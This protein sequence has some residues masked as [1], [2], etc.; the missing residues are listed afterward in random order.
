M[1]QITLSSIQFPSGHTVDES[2]ANARSLLDEAG[3]RGS[4]IVCLP[5]AYPDRAMA[6]HSEARPDGPRSDERGGVG[7]EHSGGRRWPGAWAAR[8]SA[9]SWA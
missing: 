3:R 1:G 4:D 7:R 8:R 9:C 5:E 6:T 2:I